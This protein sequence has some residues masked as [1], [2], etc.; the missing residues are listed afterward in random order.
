MR[1]LRASASTASE[2]L[3]ELRRIGLVAVDPQ[4]AY[5]FAAAT[6]ALEQLATELSELYSLK[7]RAVMHAILSAPSDRIRTFADAFRIRKDPS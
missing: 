7:P 4:G 3:A 1:E 2:G 5:S 6:P